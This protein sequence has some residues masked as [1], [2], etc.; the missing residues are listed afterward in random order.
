MWPENS[1]L[2]FRFSFGDFVCS[3][4]VHICTGIGRKNGREFNNS[5]SEFHQQQGITSASAAYMDHFYVA[6]DLGAENC[7]VMLGRLQKERLIVS[8]ARRFPNQPLKEKNFI[9]WN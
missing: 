5:R 2:E 9:H 7:R 6:G 4:S 8:E 3:L 1:L